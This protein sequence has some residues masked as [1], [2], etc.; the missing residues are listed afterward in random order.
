MKKWLAVGALGLVALAGVALAQNPGVGGIN[1]TAPT[2]NEQINAENTGPQITWMYLH[3]I[4]NANGYVKSTPSTGAT[5]TLLNTQSQ[6]TILGG[7]TLTTLAVVLPASPADGQWV[8]IYTKP[9]ITTLTIT[10]P[11]G[12]TL[13]DAVTSMSATTDVGYIYSASNTS[14]DRTQ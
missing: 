4:R 6:L 8:N 12:A 1:I 10:A 13:N 2:G 5:I 7:V 9:A 3:Q 14:W 11:G